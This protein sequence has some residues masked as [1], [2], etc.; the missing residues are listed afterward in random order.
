MLLCVF[1]VYDSAAE[2][3]MQPFFQQTK[4]QA[5]RAFTDAVNDPSHAFARYPDD[6]TLFELGSYDDSK[7]AFM[8]LNTPK[9]IGVAVEF[10]RVT[11]VPANVA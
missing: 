4:G 7:G 6:Y 8:M 3:Y 5:I 2:C 10:K 1:S 9:S 11:D